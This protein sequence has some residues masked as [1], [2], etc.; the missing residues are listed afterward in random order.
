MPQNLHVV[1]GLGESGLSCVRYLHAKGVPVAVVDTRKAPPKLLDFIETYPDIR[2]SLGKLD[3]P[4]L[5]EADK[6]ILSP[7]ISIH[8]PII[9]RQQ[10][11]GAV[12]LGD[13][14]LFA[15]HVD[16]PV[17]AITGTNAKSTVTTL[18]GLMMAEAGLR[19]KVGGNLGTPALDL[20]GAH[21]PEVYVLE[22]SS[23]QLET[24]QSLR[25]KVATILNITPDHLDR[26]ITLEN[27][28]LAKQQVY[29]HCQYAICNRDD[30]Q[31]DAAD[32]FSAQKFYF[33]L[34]SPG[35]N[36]F[37]LIENDNQ[38]YL[39]FENQALL[40]VSDLPIAGKH[41]QANALAALAIGH[42]FGLSM[43]TMLA[44]LIAFKGL[45]HR[46][47]LVKIKNDIAWYNDSK[48]TNVGATLAAINGLGGDASGKL[49]LI[50]GGVGKNAD[51]SSLIP[52]AKR[53]V[54]KVVLIGEVADELERLFQGHIAT[55]RASSMEEAIQFAA[56]SAEPKDS[57]LLSP[58]CASF[59]MFKNFEHRGNVFTQLVQD[60]L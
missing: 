4:L 54:R 25:P 8:E 10:Q 22:L 3:S 13:I 56:A 38:S 52:A 32:Q 37:G 49:I 30:R 27:Y 26:H 34:S 33:T 18:V 15:Q 36:E 48:G 21:P 12:I 7:S 45:P 43:D 40:A 51:F 47:Q 23:F 57:V 44:T 60:L 39:A 28:V 1:V 5:E 20:L 41:Y 58:A 14:E 24:T 16:A 11:R 19:V 9:A 53:Y 2:I 59:D 6:I 50:A 31:T 42:A 55:V 29:Q 46:C 17:I 35:A